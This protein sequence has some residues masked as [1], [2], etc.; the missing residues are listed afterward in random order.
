[1]LQLVLVLEDVKTT[2]V[3]I[4]K[5]FERAWE[6]AKSFSHVYLPT[7]IYVAL[8]LTLHC[9][10]TL[11]LFKTPKALNMSNVG[12]FFPCLI[13]S[14]LTTLKEAKSSSNANIAVSTINDTWR[15]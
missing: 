4:G 2:F 5:I 11:C 13:I 7:R 14:V 3:S 6:T 8:F 9:S 10:I 12:F 15:I 1:M